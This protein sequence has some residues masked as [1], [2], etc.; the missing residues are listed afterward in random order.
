LTW[1]SH[2]Q[3]QLADGSLQVF[4]VYLATLVWDGQTRTTDAEAT[5][6]EPLVGMSLLQ[7]FELRVEV[8]DGGSVT[9]SDLP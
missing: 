6:S 8:K 2:L 5:D 4:D 9:V 1:L 7:G 3:G